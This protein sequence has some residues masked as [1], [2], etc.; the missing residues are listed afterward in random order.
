[1]SEMPS[2]AE[3]A[4]V[5]SQVPPAIQALI[6][7]GAFQPGGA[8]PMEP[9]LQVVGGYRTSPG[10]DGGNVTQVEYVNEEQFFN[11]LL[12]MDID[13]RR[14]FERNLFI[15]GFYPRNVDIESVMASGRMLP[16]SLKAAE[17]FFSWAATVGDR[18]TSWQMLAAEGAAQVMGAG[19]DGG[20]GGGFGGGG[21]AEDRVIQLGDDA[22][23]A[24]TLRETYR[25]IVGKA[26]TQAEER[27]FVAAIHGMQRKQ[28]NAIYDARARAQ[29]DS[30]EIEGVDVGAQAE[31]FTRTN[32]PLEAGGMEAVR[33]TDALRNTIRGAG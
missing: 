24:Q 3:L 8:G 27:A 23:I 17:T 20:M 28:Q 30:L 18:N 22:G 9:E 4:Q 19:G 26:P 13:E 25:N 29:Q 32:E 11:Q 31:D 15:M 7:S 5:E 12:S 2:A 21:S 10:A 14:E 16:D 1:M 6:D 33:Q